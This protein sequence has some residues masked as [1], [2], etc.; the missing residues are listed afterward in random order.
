[1]KSKEALKRLALNNNVKT[2][3]YE[4]NDINKKREDIYFSDNANTVILDDDYAT[5]KH[6][7]DK[8]SRIEKVVKEISNV[9]MI[10]DY[11]KFDALREIQQILEEEM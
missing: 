11:K 9:R 10:E 2:M 7:L 3:I 1:M 6:D 5:I 8:L 4:I